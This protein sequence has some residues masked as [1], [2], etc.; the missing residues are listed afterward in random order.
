MSQYPLMAVIFKIVG[1][2]WH[3][4]KRIYILREIELID[5]SNI[6]IKSYILIELTN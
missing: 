3:N 4:M 6:D 5:F 2:P 1:V